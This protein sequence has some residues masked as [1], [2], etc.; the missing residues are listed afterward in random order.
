MRVWE[1]FGGPFPATSNQNIKC[2][3]ARDNP[4]R[5]LHLRQA[6]KDNNPGLLHHLQ[7]TVG[8]RSTQELG[9]LG[10]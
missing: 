10:V 9:G 3:K 7:H 1:V 5:N 2:R 4:L 8:H 6:R